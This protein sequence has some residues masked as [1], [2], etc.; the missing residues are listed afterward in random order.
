MCGELE[1]LE[2]KEEYAIY[3][4]NGLKGMKISLGVIKKFVKVMD[5]EGS[6]FAFL[7]KFP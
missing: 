4:S 3:H 7:Y 6:W 2:E 5:K 1:G